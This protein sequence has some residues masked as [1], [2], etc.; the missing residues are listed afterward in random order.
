MPDMGAVIFVPA[1]VG[2]VVFGFLFA[3]F[4][5]HHYLTVLQSTAAGARHVTWLSEPILD[6]F[7]KVWYLAWLIGLWLG[8][9]W[10]LGRA[11]AG[12]SGPVWVKFAVPLAVF[13]LC[14]PVSQLSSLGGPT[15][16]LPLHPEA[17]DRLARRPAAALGF[18]LLSGGVLAGLGL[19][20]Y[21]T[22]LANGV[23][24]L[25]GGSVLLVVMWLLYARL[26]GRLAFALMFTR[27]IFEPKVKKEPPARDRPRTRPRVRASADE[28][29]DADRG[30]T[31]PSDLPP[32]ETPDEGPLT[33]YDV[34]F[35]DPPPKP[36]KPRKRLKAEVVRAEPVP[37][38]EPEPPPKPNKRRP[39]VDE[40]DEGSYG[41]GA[42]E[43]V[44]EETTPREVV[45]ASP[46]ELRLFS[47]ERAVKPPKR[48]WTA[49]VLA[50]LGQAETVAS[51]G[52]LT[53]CCLA[54]GGMVRIAREFN[55]APDGP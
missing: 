21:F 27:S 3:L 15:I 26:I 17:F 23:P 54:V 34:R 41:V 32:I 4:A 33:G 11:W 19:G 29:E 42:P 48:V 28:G 18:M 52:V 5:A 50:F 8:P 46:A 45:R 6:H 14:Y 30:F 12:G 53:L 1:L 39:V 38:A 7:W 24:T 25:V 51:V 37:D 35:A 13:W 55:P 10:L 20:F 40:E 49:E 47:K 22:F 36:N 16:W 31:Q 9:A 43:V 2:A 44:P